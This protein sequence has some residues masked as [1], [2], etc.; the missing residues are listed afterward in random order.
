MKWAAYNGH[1]K[2]VQW[3]YT[4]RDEDCIEEAI[5]CAVHNGHLDIVKW[6]ELHLDENSSEL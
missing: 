6:L 3:I 2:V 4:H 1:L 5:D